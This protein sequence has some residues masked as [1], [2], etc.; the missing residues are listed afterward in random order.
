LQLSNTGGE[1][2]YLYGH[3]K[4]VSGANIRLTYLAAQNGVLIDAI[5]NQKLT[6]DCACDQPASQTNVVR[7]IN[8]IAIEDVQIV[9]DG[10]CTEVTTSGDQIL[11]RDKCSEPCCDCPELT[12]LT[13]S[14]KILDATVSNLE[15][16]AQQLDEHIRTFVTNYIL[17]R[18]P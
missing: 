8:G 17:T 15:N 11:I 5:G 10:Q 7:T 3:I 18:I 1:T 16:Y 12:M 14:L 13:D 9:G 2:D 6:D 4:L